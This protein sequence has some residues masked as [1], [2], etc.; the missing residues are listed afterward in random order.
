MNTARWLGPF[1]LTLTL[2]GAQVAELPVYL[3]DNHVGAFFHL[4][5]AL[6]LDEEVTLVL[7]DHHSDASAVPDSDAVREGLRDASS[8]AQREARLAE[9]RRNG[10]IQAFNWIEPLMP[11]PIAK[12]VWVPM[13]RI[14]SKTAKKLR[15]EAGDHIDAKLTDNPRA[16][17]RL[18]P[19]FVVADWAGLKEAVGPGPCVATLD[20]DYFLIHPPAKR[21][22]EVRRVWRK[23][24]GLPKLRDLS[25]SVSRPWLES[26]ETAAQLVHAALSQALGT[27]NAR[28]Q[29]EPFAPEGPDRSLKAR[30]FY[31]KGQTPPRF[32]LAT[33][34]QDL[35]RLLLAEG[36][37]LRVT[38]SPER[39]RAA[40]DR[41]RQEAGD[42]RVVLDD[43]Q[44]SAD[45]VYRLPK[46]ARPAARARSAE[47][48]SAPGLTRWFGLV[49]ERAVYNVLP[50]LPAGKM[51][52]STAPPYIQS[53]RVPLGE[54]RDGALP[55][56]SW[57]KLLDANAGTGVVRVEAEVALADGS[58]FA[59]TPRAEWRVQK[60][61][62]F[63][64]G[65][66]EQFGLPYVFGVGF[67][68]EAGETGPETGAG[69]DCANFLVYAWRRAGRALPWCNPAQLRDHLRV[70]ASDLSIESRPLI[71][72]TMIEAG[73]VVHL[74]SHVAAV[75]EDRE[76]LGAL[77]PKDLV[78]HHL[79][80]LP[81]IIPLERLLQDRAKPTFDLLAAPTEARIRLVV[82]GDLMLAKTGPDEPPPFAEEIAQADFAVANLEC[83]LAPA[84][85]PMADKAMSFRA[86]P[87]MAEW[88][89]RFGFDAVSLA[90]NHSAD[91]G[92]AGLEST[93]SALSRQGIQFFGTSGWEIG[94]CE[95]AGLI[96]A[97]VGVN[98]IPAGSEEG[99]RAMIF[100][101]R[102][103]AAV[104]EKLA[105]LKEEP[106]T[107]VV[108]LAHWGQEYVAT[109]NE[110]QGHWARW[111]IDH[112]A[113]A[114]IGCHTHHPQAVDSYRGRPIFYSLGNLVFP[115]QGPNESWRTAAL[116]VLDFGQDGRCWVSRMET[117][118]PMNP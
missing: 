12:V 22:E 111:L 103:E 81:E 34:S 114:V 74:G 117:R 52:A 8:E 29:F 2:A 43:Y 19:R 75:W 104:Q 33:A 76:P 84:E 70:L 15:R 27:A 45:G 59:L 82:G 68:R 97:F 86:D 18:S 7:V 10:R 85:T 94:R 53:K 113:D 65:L 60:G 99:D 37:R 98:L 21:A 42:W 118:P 57:A 79:S 38:H 28:V 106:Q 107:R 14:S 64:A 112:G 16:S 93:R 11:L 91:A 31:R 96:L 30:E 23:L 51:F 78:A 17:G 77:S 72:P 61:E 3:E 48:E 4:A 88:L 92:A 40:L 71:S 1:C 105:E 95:K 67:L 5:S 50:E 89:G 32:D 100:L 62:G 101:P 63:R 116:A 49:P 56:E 90:N 13:E 39:W 41:W 102:D 83:A 115:G 6:P 35:R 26:D 108:V 54:T 73:L 46:G 69:N 47:G 80:G 20:L 58:T 109:L 36:H 66:S 110:E 55:E 9:W 24:L 87:R 44:P 25:L